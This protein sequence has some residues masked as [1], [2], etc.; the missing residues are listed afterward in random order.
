VQ[1]MKPSLENALTRNGGRN[2]GNTSRM[3]DKVLIFKNNTRPLDRPWEAHLYL[4][5]TDY[6]MW[7]P[8]AS[9]GEAYDRLYSHLYRA[10]IFIKPRK[11]GI[12]YPHGR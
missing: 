6:N 12:Y 2:G 4:K 10:S 1:K 3:G 9:P 7:S 8:G 11:G 5:G